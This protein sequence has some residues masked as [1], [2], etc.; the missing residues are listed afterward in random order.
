MELNIGLKITRIG[1]CLCNQVDP[2]YPLLSGDLS[3][4]LH[5]PEDI[6]YLELLL[7]ETLLR[8]TLVD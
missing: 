7:R 1:I 2:L 4:E 5:I 6:E 8:N 3:R